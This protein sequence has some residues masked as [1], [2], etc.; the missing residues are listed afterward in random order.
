MEIVIR[1]HNGQKVAEVHSDQVIISD[2][3]SALDLMAD[4]NYQHGC[5]RISLNHAAMRADFFDLRTGLAGE[6]LQKFTN[7]QV[8]FALVGDFTQYSSRS[9]RDFIYESNRGS[10]IFFV[11]SRQEALDKLSPG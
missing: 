10:H 6:I 7:Y 11:A 2:V 3:N 4:V 8:K 5:Q 1:E 9:L